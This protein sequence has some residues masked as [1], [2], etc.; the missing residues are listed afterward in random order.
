MRHVWIGL[1]AAVACSASVT[2]QDV[3][4]HEQTARE[5]LIE[6]FT[7]KGE[8]DFIKH[9]PDAARAALVHKGETAETSM[10]LRVSGALRGLASQG[11]NVQT[12]AEG[13]NILVLENTSSHESIEIAVEHDSLSGEEDEIE[14]SVHPYKNGEPVSLPVVPRLIFTLKQEKDIW[15]VSELTA[16]AHV[17]LEDPDYLKSLRKQQDEA[18]ES[19][20]Q[21][22]VNMI[23]QMEANYA[24]IHADVGY[25]CTL[26]SLYSNAEGEGNTSNP[27][28]KEEFNG[29]RIILSGCSGKP[30]A[31]YRLMA[32]PVEQES[33]MKAFCAD[34]SG[35]VKSIPNDDN[36]SCLSQGKVLNV[37][38]A[39]T[40]EE[41]PDN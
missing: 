34:Q 9:L 18:N 32:L 12:F 19:A 41:N 30:A 7:G 25:V 15:R 16:S 10:L 6:M 28:A 27:L 31:K 40:A 2:A 23:A 13:P 36:A 29:Y 20:A 24:A 4:T 39:T 21:M 17:P 38:T 22:R 37:V 33:E 3:T 1:L 11:E 5:A 35:S 26:A 14:L 8:N